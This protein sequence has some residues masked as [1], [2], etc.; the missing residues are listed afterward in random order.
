MYAAPRRVTPP[1][2]RLAI[3]YITFDGAS[4]HATCAAVP[5]ARARVASPPARAKIQ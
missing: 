2:W 4:V 5:G 1:P 3:T